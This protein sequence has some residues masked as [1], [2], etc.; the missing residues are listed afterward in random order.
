MT[1]ITDDEFTV[2]MIAAEGESMMP[3]GRWEKPVISLVAKGLMKSNDKFNNVITDAGREAI[4]QRD[5]DD[6]KVYRDILVKSGQ[7]ADARNHAA[8]AVEEAARHLVSAVKASSMATGH[9][10]SHALD[11]WMRVLKDRCKEL[12]EI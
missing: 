6:D 10:S 5:K 3:I 8:G 9:A 11:E 7:I 4:K 1:D 12:L 2:L